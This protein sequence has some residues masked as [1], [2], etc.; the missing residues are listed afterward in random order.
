M[1]DKRAVI[2]VS[3]GLD[4]TTVLAMA[5][6]EGYACY[7]LSF[8]YGQRHRAELFAAERV[9]AALGDVEHKVVKLNLDS[10]GGSALTDAAIA[11][12]EEETEGIPVTYV[13]ARNTVFLSIALG[14][15]EVLGAQDIFIGVNAVD[16]SGYP[17]CRPAYIAAFENMANL[18]TRAGVE[19]NRL[20]IHTPLMDLGKGE[21]INA[22]LALGVDYAL[23]VSCYQATDAGL[24]CGKCDACRLRARGFAD[25]GVDD[26][27]PYA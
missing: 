18:A 5:R 11:V 17:D 8:D 26:P 14:W 19:G 1:T 21:I 25:A 3:G 20:R 15:A 7:T 16:Y 2:L 4:S 13:P 22:G 12:P 10:I 6:S 27:T 24:A 9:S 23:T